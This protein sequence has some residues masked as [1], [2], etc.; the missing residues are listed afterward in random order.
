[1]K[2][3]VSRKGNCHDNAVLESFFGTLK[4]ECFYLKEH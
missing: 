3:S 1:M 2:Q 4:T